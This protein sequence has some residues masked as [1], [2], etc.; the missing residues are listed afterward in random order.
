MCME[1]WAD[2]KGIEEELEAVNSAKETPQ[3]L[4]GSSVDQGLAPV[5]HRP[6]QRKKKQMWEQ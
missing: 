5:T 3:S 2:S 1:G 4:E 6:W